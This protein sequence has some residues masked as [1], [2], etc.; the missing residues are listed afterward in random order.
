MPRPNDLPDKLPTALP[1]PTAPPRAADPDSTAQRFSIGELAREFDLTTRAI[2]FYEDVGLLDPQRA[3]RQR[4]YSGRDRT[5][6][7]LTLRGKRLGLSL[8]EIKQLV[9]MYESPSD[10][11]P[12]LHAFLTVLAEHRELLE[13]QRTDLDLTLAE[14]AQHEARCR[15]LLKLGAA[16]PGHRKLRVANPAKAAILP[17]EFGTMAEPPHLHPKEPS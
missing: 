13:R 11:A 14:I 17:V 6:L 4:V 5:R 15:A 1:E 12:Q 16:R 10:T 9:D 2:R 8:N 3:G 7:K